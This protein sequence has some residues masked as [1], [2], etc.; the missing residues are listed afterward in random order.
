MGGHREGAA[1]FPQ[2]DKQWRCVSVCERQKWLFGTIW[3][4]CEQQRNWY[5]CLGIE[6]ACC[7]ICSQTSSIMK[8]G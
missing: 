3:K 8:Y 7:S 5:N 2:A 1:I 6:Q 4:I